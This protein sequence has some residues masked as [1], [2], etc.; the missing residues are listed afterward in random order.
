[1]FIRKRKVKLK[2]GVISE[3]Y[4]AVFSYRH[5]GKVKQDVVGLGKYSNPKKYLQDWELYLV[6]M[7]EDLNI[8]LGNYKEI[9]YSKLFK[10]SI[11]FK[12]PLSVAQK[13]RAN[14][15]RR[16]EKEKSKCTKLKK[17]CNKIK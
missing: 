16:Y 11:I 7:D 2:N 17:L 4:Q 12:V 14:L 10:T 15:M 1:M 8:P 3:I 13:K 6:K 9:R 5:E